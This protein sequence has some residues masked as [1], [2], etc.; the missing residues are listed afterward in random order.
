MTEPKKIFVFADWYY[1]GAP[2][3]MGVL[4][5]NAIRGKEVFSFEYDKAWLSSSNSQLIDPDLQL[6]AGKQYLDIS[7]KANFG[8]FDF[9]QF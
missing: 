8:V 7:K 6:Y 3:L 1:L 4:Q 2:T 5:A 9:Y